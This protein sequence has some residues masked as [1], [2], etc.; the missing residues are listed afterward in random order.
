MNSAALQEL[1]AFIRH[2]TTAIANVSL[3]SLEHRQVTLLCGRAGKNLRRL[4]A[5]RTELCF[6]LID[7]QLVVDE[8]PLE[9]SLAQ[10]RLIKA[11][12]QG[13]IGHLQLSAG[14][15]RQELLELV[16][17]LAHGGR[18]GAPFAA[19][20]HVRYGRVEV[21]LARAEQNDDSAEPAPRLSLEDIGVTEIANFHELYR[22]A[23]QRKKLNV[24]GL[25]HIVAS[26]VEAFSSHSNPLLAL[27]PLRGMDEY[28]YTHSTN[29]CLLNLAQ[30][31]SLGIEGRLLHEIG[32]ASMLHD[33][34]KLF[35]P[36]EV[37]RKPGKLD[38]RE[39]ELIKDHPRKGAEYLLNTPGVPR[40]AVLT[41]FEHHMRYDGS[42]YPVTKQDWQPHLCSHMTSISDFYD[43]L[44]SHRSYCA[45][46]SLEQTGAIMLEQA[47]SGLHPQLTRNFLQALRQKE[48]APEP[49]DA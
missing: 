2:L 24:T 21:R 23:R 11:L 4:L 14:I 28:T 19:S 18:S 26:F 12:K 34:G 25:D 22:A 41:A 38:D 16:A 32:I 45:G 44:R 8:T 10:E 49:S 42:G 9:Y 15:D 37:L 30:A 35:V 36:V 48:G 39:W 1:Q 13:G 47:G 46:L 40:L 3:Y 20:E 27:A 6:M 17:T 7:N 5:E 31:R 29:V 33:I 43:A